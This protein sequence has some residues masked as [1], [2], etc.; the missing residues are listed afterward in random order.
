MEFYAVFTRW[1]MVCQG[2][3]HMTKHTNVVVRDVEEEVRR[4]LVS[5]CWLKNF[6][7]V[8]YWEPLVSFKM[9][10]RKEDV[11]VKRHPFRVVIYEI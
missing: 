7:L 1:G 6:L 10:R 8:A 2:A 5:D 9:S 11:P 3:G 4:C